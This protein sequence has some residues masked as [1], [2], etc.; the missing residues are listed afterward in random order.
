VIIFPSNSKKIIHIK[1]LPGKIFLTRQ[2]LEKKKEETNPD[3]LAI[4]VCMIPH[5]G[6][7]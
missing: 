7:K 5:Y 3:I 6:M 1:Y 4:G 2:G